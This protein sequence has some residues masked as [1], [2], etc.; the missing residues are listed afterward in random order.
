MPAKTAKAPFRPGYR[1][2][3]VASFIPEGTVVADIGTD[4]AYLP[5]Y[6]V[7]QKACP[8]I[9]AVEKSQKNC[10]RA[11]EV[12]SLFNLEHKIEV[13]CADGLPALREEDGVAVIVIAGLGGK[14]ICR[15]LMAAGN[16][17]ERYRR[18]VLQPMGDAPLLR[19]WLVARGFALT[20]ERLAR[21]K[22]HF[23]EI[24]A[25]ER[26]RMHVAD[27]FYY[28]LGPALLVSRDPLLVPWLQQKIR[29]CERILEGL[30]KAGSGE[31]EGRYRYYVARHKRLKDVLLDVC[32]G[33]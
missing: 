12:V 5:L 10:D 24:I 31:R 26:G 27:P 1:L 7:T 4:H 20:A 19:R 3:A 30:Q 21:E 17:L 25:A 13:R 32:Y 6:L 16:S 22:G 15:L 14:T 8:R 33:K 2:A 18:L 28:E 23:Y 11:R 29:R 9:L